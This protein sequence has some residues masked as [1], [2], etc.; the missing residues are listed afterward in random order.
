MGD[1]QGCRVFKISGVRTL[2]QSY[3]PQKHFERSAAIQT[4]RECDPQ[5]GVPKFSKYERLF[6]EPRK[7][8]P[9]TPEQVFTFLVKKGVFQV[10]LSL[11][12]PHCELEPWIP[13]DDV[14]TEVGCEYCGKN[15]LI[16]P[17]LRDRNW[18]YRR[19]GLFGRENNQEGSVPVV[20]T[21]Q[22]LDSTLHDNRIFTTNMLIEP[23]SARIEPCETDFVLIEQGFGSDRVSVAVGECKTRKEISEDDVRKLSLVA[24]VFE[25][26]GL[27]AFIVFSKIDPFTADEIARCRVAQ[28][29]FGMRVIMLTNR[30]LEA[31]YFMYEQTEKEFMIRPSAGYLKGLAESTDIIY[32]HPRPKPA[33]TTE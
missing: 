18:K 27:D 8:G 16:T 6:I 15:F 33:P 28:G 13:L 1:I 21:L 17:Q 9:L 3:G 32:F 10:G 11:V 22:Q 12:C 20:L 14:A 26:N 29:N 31:T 25:E 7:H 30:E 5:T 2:L 24:D 19:S 23:I 4:I